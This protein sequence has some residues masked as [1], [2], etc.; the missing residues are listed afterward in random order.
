MNEMTWRELADAIHDMPEA[1][2]DDLACVWLPQDVDW[3][4]IEFVDFVELSPYDRDAAP[5]DDN[6]YSLSTGL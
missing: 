2:K 1:M 6:P 3:S 5:G 4:R